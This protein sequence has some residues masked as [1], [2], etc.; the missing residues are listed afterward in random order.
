MGMNIL[1][2]SRESG[3]LYFALVNF[4][5]V[6]PFF[7]GIFEGTVSWE[8]KC[9]TDYFVSAAKCNVPRWFISSL[10]AFNAVMIDTFLNCFSFIFDLSWAAWTRLNALAVASTVT[11]SHTALNFAAM[12]VEK[13]CPGITQGIVQNK[14]PW[15]TTEITMI[16]HLMTLHGL[17]SLENPTRISRPNKQAKLKT[18]QQL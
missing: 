14:L 17:T 9:C 13:L 18:E 8:K 3:L 5:E 1:H 6:F 7:S 15:L 11:S 10:W 4:L 2:F 16:I 12:S